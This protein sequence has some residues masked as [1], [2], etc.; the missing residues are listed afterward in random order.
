MGKWENQMEE[1]ILKE[2]IG[3]KILQKITDKT[4]NLYNFIIKY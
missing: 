4:N 2:I 3:I 1:N